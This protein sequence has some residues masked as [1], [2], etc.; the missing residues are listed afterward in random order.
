VP[1]VGELPDPGSE[2]DFLMN[3]CDEEL[4]LVAD[5]ERSFGPS[6]PSGIRIELQNHYQF[7]GDILPAAIENKVHDG[8]F[9]TYGAAY[10]WKMR[11]VV[12]P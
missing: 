10:R 7:W 6:I 4:Q 3:Q 12:N 8:G 1:N 2:I 5:T 11:D 9:E